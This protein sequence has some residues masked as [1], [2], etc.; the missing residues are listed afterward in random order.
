MRTEHVNCCLLPN[1]HILLQLHL[2]TAPHL[3]TQL[4]QGADDVGSAVLGQRAWDN[5]HGHAHLWQQVTNHNDNETQLRHLVHAKAITKGTCA[6]TH[7]HLSKQSIH[8]RPS[9]ER[10]KCTRTPEQAKYTQQAVVLNQLMPIFVYDSISRHPGKPCYEALREG[11][12]CS[13]K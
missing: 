10:A 2:A 7:A 12:S 9:P 5:L 6:A 1:K 4:G 11:Q 13:L 3:G 8:S